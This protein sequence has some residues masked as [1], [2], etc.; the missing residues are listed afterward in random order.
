MEDIYNLTHTCYN[1]EIVLRS[2]S[3]LV[4]VKELNSFVFCHNLT[5]IFSRAAIISSWNGARVKIYLYGVPGTFLLPLA[6]HVFQPRPPKLRMTCYIALSTNDWK[7]WET[8]VNNTGPSYCSFTC[9][10]SSLPSSVLRIKIKLQ[11]SCTHKN[12]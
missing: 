11:Y 12:N 4:I 9:T 3:L 8:L 6:G 7:A 1:P 2:C 5:N 10:N